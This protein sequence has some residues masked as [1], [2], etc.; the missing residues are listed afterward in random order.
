MIRLEISSRETVE[1]PRPG[2]DTPPE[3]DVQRLTLYLQEWRDGEGPDVTAV[4]AL[5]NDLVRPV[6]Q[7]GHRK[8]HH[9]DSWD[10]G[11]CSVSGCNCSGYNDPAVV[12]MQRATA[13]ELALEKRVATLQAMDVAQGKQLVETRQW[14]ADAT[15]AAASAQASLA[16]AQGR[17]RA[18]ARGT[19]PKKKRRR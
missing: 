12:A 10:Q 13:R 7:C 11:R 4:M 5:V 14:A 9:L 18:L 16:R 17:A 6:C 15:K 3:F 19:A 2:P 8:Q 1:R